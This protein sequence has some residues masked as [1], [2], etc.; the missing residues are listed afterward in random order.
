MP[1]SC[2]GGQCCIKSVENEFGGC[3]VFLLGWQCCINLAE[4]RND[5]YGNGCFG[6]MMLYQIDEIPG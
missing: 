4:N 2:L 5:A 3:S 1:H 6:M